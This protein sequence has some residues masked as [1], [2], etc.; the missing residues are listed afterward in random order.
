MLVKLLKYLQGYVKI[1]VEG[2]SPERLLNLC[3]AN[4]ILLWEVETNQFVYEMCIS[5]KDYR[6][7]RPFARKTGT[8]IILLEKHGLPFFLH[9]FRKRKMFFCGMLLSIAVIYGLSLFVWNIHIEGNNTQST[10]ELIAYLETIGV[11][12]GKIKKEIVCE[13]IETGLRKQY[14]NMLWVSAQ[15]QG[16]RIIIRIKEN[17]DE[18]IITRVE[19]KEQ[20]PKSIVSEVAGTIHSMIVRKGTSEV[21]V[22]EEVEVGQIL[23]NGY[24]PVINDAGEILRYEGVCADADIEIETVESYTDSF[25]TE[26]EMKHY[27]KRKRFGCRVT[28]F[29]KNFELLPKI[30]Y[31]TY[32]FVSKKMEIH[33]TENFYLPLE[34]ENFWY[35]EYVSEPR[36]YSE[37]QLK[38]IAME[39]F[40]KKYENNLQK[41][42]Q[43]IEK[44]VRINT[45]GKLCR[46][47]G[48][49]KTM[50]PITKKVP[51]KMP[52]LNHEASLEGEH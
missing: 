48:T 12:H 6:K 17:E 45:N 46:V 19:L 14:P 15:M 20:I 7:L 27:T 37:K 25:S 39:R 13:E 31:E 23:V 4:H 42:V 18:D 9:R 38:K 50:V 16:T 36:I 26:Y 35:L 30:P 51:V 49:V 2:Y 21:S 34:L 44:D 1:R 41:G 47:V 11:S 29:G 52:E 3:N 43:I 28:I 10:S 32:E 33:L 24:Y 8:K 40:A 22:G 5:I